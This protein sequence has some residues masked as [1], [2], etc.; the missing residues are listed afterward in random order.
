MGATVTYQVRVLRLVEDVVEVDALTPSDAEDK[1]LRERGV[2][3]VLGIMP[4][5]PESS[6]LDDLAALSRM[7]R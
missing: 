2:S 6:I 4:D 1:A 3:R 7:A 5:E